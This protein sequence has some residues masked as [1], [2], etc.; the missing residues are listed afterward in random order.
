MITRRKSRFVFR[1]VSIDFNKTNKI[2]SPIISVH[3]EYKI[4]K[5]PNKMFDFLFVYIVKMPGF[6][7]ILV[8]IN[9]NKF[10]MKILKCRDEFPTW[11]GIVCLPFFFVCGVHTVRNA[12]TVVRTWNELCVLNHQTK[13]L[14]NSIFSPVRSTEGY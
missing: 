8:T 6:S 3:Q 7:H 9:K 10:Q 13:N 14:H 4:P 1:Q 2:A 12:N 5:I 11:I